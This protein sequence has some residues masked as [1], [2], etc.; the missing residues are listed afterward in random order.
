MANCKR[1]QVLVHERVL[2]VDCS[3]GTR[4]IACGA[5]DSGAR[6]MS[7]SVDSHG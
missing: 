1:E 4:A 7:I 5:L 6:L 3:S 2:D